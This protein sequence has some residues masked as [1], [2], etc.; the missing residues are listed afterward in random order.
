MI[1]VALVSAVPAA[2]PPAEAAVRAAV[3]DARLWNL[4]DDRLIADAIERDGV[5]DELADRM[6][7]LVEYAEIGGADAVLVTCSLYADIAARLDS[8]RMPVLGSDD[9]MW[10]AAARAGYRS[11]HVVSSVPIALADSTRR[12]RLLF[13]GAVVPVLVAEARRPSL[14]RD[15]PAVAQ[16]IANAITASDTPV[17]A[18]ALAN[19]SLADAAEAIAQLTGSPVLSGPTP[20]AQDLRA[21]I[22]TAARSR[23]STP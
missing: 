1:L 2:I 13:P 19:Y 5:T 23:V 4:I 14:E 22:A 8:P 9:A 10:E 6:R 3:P 7:R 21:R 18:I 17:E 12:A 15:T 20:A 11:L 16:A